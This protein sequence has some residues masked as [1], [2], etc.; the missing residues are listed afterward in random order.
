MFEVLTMKWLFVILL[1][2]FYFIHSYIDSTKKMIFRSINDFHYGS[3]ELYPVG[4]NESTFST[5]WDAQHLPLLKNYIFSHLDNEFT[6]IIK[7]FLYT[8]QRKTRISNYSSVLILSFLV[9]LHVLFVHNYN[10]PSMWISNTKNM[11]MISL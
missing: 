9:Q 4:T 5:F 1:T 10:W 8:K 7:I 3:A 11:F 6:E 2:F